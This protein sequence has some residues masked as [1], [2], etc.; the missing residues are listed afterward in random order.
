MQRIMIRDSLRCWF[1]KGTIVHTKGNVVTGKRW[2]GATITV[3]HDF[4]EA[5]DFSVNSTPHP[6][7]G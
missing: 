3:Q 5:L 2:D 4:T 7:H 1:A 6:S